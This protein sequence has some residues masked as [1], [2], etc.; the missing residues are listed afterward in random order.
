M[1]VEGRM[2]KMKTLSTKTMET[3]HPYTVTATLPQHH[4]L[5]N[6]LF[7]TFNSPCLKIRD[8]VTS[9]RIAKAEAAAAIIV[10]AQRATLASV[11]YIRFL[12]AHTV[13]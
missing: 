5:K 10:R 11:L 3:S 8:E 12:I 1:G 7:N 9:T 6:Q 4:P 2:M 13:Y